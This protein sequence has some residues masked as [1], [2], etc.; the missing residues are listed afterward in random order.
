MEVSK[1]DWNLFRER[2][3]QW[4]ERYGTLGKKNTSIC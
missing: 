1:S 4:Q 3:L 2:L